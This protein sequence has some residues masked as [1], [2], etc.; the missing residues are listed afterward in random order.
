VVDL[1]GSICG[2]YR[3]MSPLK[4]PVRHVLPN[5][6]VIN[7]DEDDRRLETLGTLVWL[8]KASHA[9]RALSMFPTDPAEEN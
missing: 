1:I 7:R 9:S 8:D 6:T 3:V 5:V 2:V 4:A